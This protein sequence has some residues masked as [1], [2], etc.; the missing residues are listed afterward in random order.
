MC[1]QIQ[2]K[3]ECSYGKKCLFAHKQEE[4]RVYKAKHKKRPRYL[5]HSKDVLSQL[6][7]FRVLIEPGLL[8]SLLKKE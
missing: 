1:R 6:L 8:M 2:S 4:L 5:F 7:K 3:G